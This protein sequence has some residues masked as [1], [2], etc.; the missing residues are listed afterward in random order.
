[1]YGFVHACTILT[2]GRS[3]NLYMKGLAK[4]KK[5]QDFSHGDLPLHEHTRSFKRSA[6]ILPFCHPYSNGDGIG[7]FATCEVV[8][9]RV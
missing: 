8:H 2:I 7:G 1:M 6:D 3:I 9:I 4:K 5:T